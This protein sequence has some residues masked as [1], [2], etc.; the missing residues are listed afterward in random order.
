[1]SLL[2]FSRIS[3]ADLVSSSSLELSSTGN[4]VYGSHKTI[5]QDVNIIEAVSLAKLPIYL[6]QSKITK[7]KYVMKVFPHQNG[8]PS[9]Y[10]YNEARFLCLTHPNV[11]RRLYYEKNREAELERSRIQISHIVME[12]AS[13]GDFR[14]F[15]KLHRKQMDDK[16]A[17]TYFRQLIDGLEYIH[18]NGV[19]HMDL[20]LENLL[21]GDDDLLKITDFD[22]AHFEEDTLIIGS[23]TKFYRAPEVQTG[24]CNLPKATDIYSAGVLLFLIKSQG[25]FPYREKDIKEDSEDFWAKHCEAQEREMDF[26]DQDFQDLFMSMTRKIPEE[27]VSIKEIKGSKWYNGLIYNTKELKK[28]IGGLF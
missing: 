21:I 12:Y 3:S 6:V 1:M 18:G 22:L 17:R 5:Y 7:Q 4:V 14:N 23:G 9:F 8:Q 15:L 27:R 25:V 20:K 19:A 2:V 24:K 10:Y 13:R 16:L 28:K 26:F 11:I